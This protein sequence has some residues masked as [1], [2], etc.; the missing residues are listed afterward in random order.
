MRR[1]LLLLLS[2]GLLAQENALEKIT[3]QKPSHVRDFA[4]LRAMEA[5]LTL[6]QSLDLFMLTTRPKPAHLDALA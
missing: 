2:L 3:Q 6:S 5:N 1:L 4:I